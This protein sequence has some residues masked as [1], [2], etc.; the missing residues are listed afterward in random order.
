MFK[1]LNRETKGPGKLLL[2]FFMARKQS[3]YTFT[4]KI[5][6]SSY[7]ALRHRFFRLLFF[8][9]LSL[10]ILFFLGFFIFVNQKGVNQVVDT[11]LADIFDTSRTTITFDRDK[12]SYTLPELSGQ[13]KIE[14]Y[15]LRIASV[16]GEYQWL[17]IPKIVLSYDLLKLPSSPLRRIDIPHG[18]YHVLNVDETGEWVDAPILRQ[19]DQASG[20][21]EL[22][23]ITIENAAVIFRFPELFAEPQKAVAAKKFFGKSFE[24]QGK[25]GHY[26]SNIQLSLL[27]SHENSRHFILRG[28]TECDYWGK[29][30]IVGSISRKGELDVQVT[31]LSQKL[32]STFT[33]RF[34]KVAEV[35]ERILA[36]VKEPSP[37]QNEVDIS[38][39]IQ[40]LAQGQL[41]IQVEAAFQGAVIFREIPILVQDVN[42]FISFDGKDL[43]LLR[44]TGRRGAAEVTI[45]GSIK[46]VGTKNEHIAL[47]LEAQDLLISSE[48]RKALGDPRLRDPENPYPEWQR[49][50]LS[51]STP[52]V[53]PIVHEILGQFLL[54]GLIDLNLKVEQARD[55]RLNSFQVYAALRDMTVLYLGD[56]NALPRLAAGKTAAYGIEDFGAL[57]SLPRIL[58]RDPDPIEEE[59]EEKIGFP[60]PISNLQGVIEGQIV[61]SE[62]SVLQFRGFNIEEKERIEKRYGT[63][64]NAST[65]GM[66]AKRGQNQKLYIAGSVYPDNPW[67]QSE[68]DNSWLELEIESENLELDQAFLE[69]LPQKALGFL[70]PFRPPGSMGK[71]D[72]RK[73]ELKLHPLQGGELDAKIVL[74]A[75]N[76]RVQYQLPGAEAAIPLEG[77]QGEIHYDTKKKILTLKNMKTTFRKAD[78][79]FDLK[80]QEGSNGLELDYTVNVKDLDI[81]EELYSYLPQELAEVRNTFITPLEGRISLKIASSPSSNNQEKELKVLLS[82]GEGKVGYN[83]LQP[84]F[85]RQAKGS[86]ELIIN[87]SGLECSIHSF[88]GIPTFQTPAPLD[89]STSGKVTISGQAFMPHAEGSEQGFFNLSLNAQGLPLSPR[90]REAVIGFLS[91][92][93]KEEEKEEEP[94]K[95]K[96]L[97]T[98]WQNLEPQDRKSFGIINLKGSLSGALKSGEENTTQASSDPPSTTLDSFDYFFE[99]ELQEGQVEY[100]SFPLPLKNIYGKFLIAPGFLEFQEF[101]AE[102]DH[103]LIEFPEI[104]LDDEGNFA[105]SLW[106]KNFPLNQSL[107]AF[108][109]EN[110]RSTFDILAPE[111]LMNLFA[112]FVFT[113]EGIRFEQSMELIETDITVGVR[114][115]KCSAFMD[116]KGVLLSP[117]AAEAQNLRETERLGMKGS[118]A[119]SSAQWKGVTFENISTGFQYQA[120]LFIMPNLRGSLHE[121]VFSGSLELSTAE[122][123]SYRGRILARAISL[124]S[125]SQVLA[126]AQTQTSGE[127]LSGGVDAELSFFSANKEGLLGKGRIDIGREPLAPEELENLNSSEDFSDASEQAKAA[128]LGR[129]PLFSQLYQLLNLAEGEYFNEAH[130]TFHLMQDRMKIRELE[131]TSNIV[132]LHSV[133]G[134]DLSQYFQGQEVL[135]PE[136]LDFLAEQDMN[137]ILYQKPENGEQIMLQLVP[138]FFPRSLTVPGM[139][140][141]IDFFKGLVLRVFVTGS[142]ENPKVQPLTRKMQEEKAE[143]HRLRPAYSEIGE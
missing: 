106:T 113:E 125:L 15:N 58:G 116:G 98:I 26:L 133:G 138:T 32:D 137:Y 66:T 43:K 143:G 95:I 103:A 75:Q 5:V 45:Q 122:T 108:L 96:E 76:L 65:K 134:T 6:T 14:L 9:S 91:S 86:F 61:A 20:E 87:K 24:Y 59:P 119:F 35:L 31:K 55:P 69:L 104:G 38:A 80:A 52:E 79:T 54:N 27:K 28:K 74:H 21:F 81:H 126:G 56:M 3:E 17:H 127:T 140:L 82:F 115:E 78:I 99:I 16:T 64:L 118:I 44:A 60:L 36:E 136:T 100:L 117:A 97:G 7:R 77:V 120:G 121:G 46:D 141:L 29:T 135:A 73:A 142:L 49:Y 53:P 112:T 47:E 11:V 92:E 102:T 63:I 62:Q 4:R 57:R 70:E 123:N 48:L 68:G 18:L 128:V 1:V 33:K 107:R 90:L 40:S 71:V 83:K 124:E 34:G 130:M 22:P 13:G 25:G 105:L 41:K 93:E 84:F 94:G 89:A 67:A 19:T 10:I 111:G 2:K 85:L 72:I 50:G 132:R 114:F 30:D 88:E 37:V 110:M 39:R 8:V 42:A 109:P 129:V 51:S 23:E 12:T 139:Q 131:F 101:Q